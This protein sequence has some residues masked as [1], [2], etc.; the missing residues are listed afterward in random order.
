MNLK[1]CF[2]PEFLIVL[3]ISLLAGSGRS[4]YA[5]TSIPVGDSPWGIDVNA[6]TNHIFV[7]NQYDG[8]VSVIDGATHT[9]I[10]TVS[11]GSGPAGVGVNATTNRIYVANYNDDNV[12]V[13]DGA[14]NT[15]LHT[16]AV[17]SDPNG[18]AVNPTTNRIYVA[19][20]TS[21]TV[22]VIDGSN[23]TVLTAVTVGSAPYFAEVNADTNRI[24]VSNTFGNTVSVIDGANNTVAKTITVGSGPHGIGVNSVTN[25]IYVANSSSDTI[26]VIDGAT[27]TVID[28][29]AAGDKPYDIDVRTATN[30]YYVTNENHNTLWILNGSDN[31][32]ITT[33][34]TGTDP[35]GVAVNPAT[36]FIYVA[37]FGSDTVSV[38]SDRA[39]SI[40]Y[41]TGDGD[42]DCL[43]WASACTLRTALIAAVSGDQIWVAKGV[44]YPGSAGQRSATFTLQNGVA[45]YGGFAGAEDSL[46]QRDWRANPTI[47]SGDIDG[48]DITEPNGV[49]TDTAHIQGNNAY[50][51][52]SSSSVAATAVL[53]GFIIT[54]G[55]ANGSSTDDSGG[56]IYNYHGSPTLVNVTFSANTA[57]ASGAGIYNFEL[58]SPALTNVSFIANT[59]QD[60]GAIYNYYQSSPTLVN[61]LF[62]SNTAGNRGGGIYNNYQCSPALTNVTF[63]GNSATNSGGGIYNTSNS[64]PALVNAILWGDSAATKPEIFNN[65]SSPAIRYSDIQGCGGSG[66]GWMSACGV[67]NGGNVDTDPSFSNVAGGDLSLQTNS[68]AIDAGDNDAVPPGITTDLDGKPRF[69]NVLSRPDTGNGTPPIVDMGVYEAEFVSNSIYLPLVVRN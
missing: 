9:V 46:D 32:V 21:N 57:T 35:D 34:P 2:R 40:L 25:R 51:V 66:A 31:T 65:N 49:V 37:N 48:N 6:I 36:D 53:D 52:V 5:S 26:S 33:L 67:D 3:L 61:V 4:S 68:P 59:A 12:S 19:N 18:V 1:R 38:F 28:T 10:S 27:D 29:I 56:G 20:F 47:L 62:Y 60:G 39:P 42:G 44:H 54:A 23:D 41:A 30:R 13:I 17:G 58:C 11:V 69:V 64:D 24:Y 50:H 15:V 16:V 63:S 43:S 22:S 55:Q 45:L 14:T 8:T 7:S